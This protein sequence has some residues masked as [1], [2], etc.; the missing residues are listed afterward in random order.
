MKNILEDWINRWLDKEISLETYQKRDV[1]S[2]IDT[3]FPSFRDW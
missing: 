1:Q 3:D 2:E